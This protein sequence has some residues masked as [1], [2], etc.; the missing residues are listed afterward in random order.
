[1]ALF[2]K[3]STMKKLVL[4]ALWLSLL[5]W[6]TNAL[7][8]H[9]ESNHISQEKSAYEQS[10]S[11]TMRMEYYNKYKAKGYDLSILSDKYLDANQTNESQFWEALKQMQTV[12]E[13][14]DRRVYIEKLKNYGMDVSGF[15][16]EVISDSGKFWDMVKSV[17]SGKKMIKTKKETVEKKQKE[18]KEEVEVKKVEVKKIVVMRKVST[19]QEARLKV[20]MQNR[21]DKIPEDKREVTLDRLETLIIKRIELA[22]KK[23]SMLL[24]ARYEILLWV[25]QQEM[26]EVDDESLIA[27]LFA[28]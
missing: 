28:E 23:N 22:Q 8:V 6:G 14:D 4:S 16:E 2:I 10:K 20:L 24:V 21:L 26:V 27:D 19:K 18:V 17:E 15:T 7:W 12:N 5:V 13:I 1:M 11:N 9:A 3:S 25:I